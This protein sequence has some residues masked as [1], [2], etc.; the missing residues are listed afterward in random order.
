MICFCI[1]ISQFDNA[2]LSNCDP[3]APRIYDGIYNRVQDKEL[4]EISDLRCCMSMHQPWASLLVAG[5]KRHEGRSWYSAHRGRLW[6]AAT[7]KP[8][9]EADIQDMETFYKNHYTGV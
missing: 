8:V 4:L 6:I 2:V 9:N 7:A 5:I 1:T 3:A